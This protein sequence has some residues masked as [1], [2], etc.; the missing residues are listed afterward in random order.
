[1]SKYQNSK[2][3]IIIIFLSICFY[4]LT[5]KN[6]KII[7]SYFVSFKAKKIINVIK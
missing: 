7:Y 6:I 5:K 1:M 4:L 2:E 3:I